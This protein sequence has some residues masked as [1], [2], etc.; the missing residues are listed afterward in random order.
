MHFMVIA[1]DST[2]EDAYQRR[3]NA[4]EKHLE[5]AKRMLIEKSFCMLPHCCMI[6][7]K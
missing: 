7:I 6:T 2:D 4:R 1:Y 3:L 5:N